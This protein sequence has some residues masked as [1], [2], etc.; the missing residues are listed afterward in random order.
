[1]PIVPF[2]LI[3]LAS[4]ACLLVYLIP[5]FVALKRENEKTGVIMAIN[6]LA[7]WTIIGWIAS[8]VMAMKD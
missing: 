3:F 4:V 5:S 6:F 8:L 2:I 1:M 7:G